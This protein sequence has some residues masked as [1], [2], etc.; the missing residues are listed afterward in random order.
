MRL[1][2]VAI[3]TAALMFFVKLGDVW[4]DVQSLMVSP[5]Y[6]QETKAKPEA[7][8]PNVTA[9]A[10][11]ASGEKGKGD[12]E[13]GGNKAGDANA[14]K[15]EAAEGGKTAEGAA[16]SA[17]DSAKDK[18]GG[19]DSKTT[20]APGLPDDPALFSQAEIE[21]LQKL[22]DRR[23]ELERWASD[24]RMRERL[25]KATELRLGKKVKELK[26]IQGTLKGLL[27]QYDKEQLAK[28][29]RL[30][31]IYETM[32]PKNAA[33]VFEKLEL[34]IL[35]DVIELMR[36]AKAAKIMGRMDVTIAKRITAELARRRKLD[37]TSTALISTPAPIPAPAAAPPAPAPTAPPAP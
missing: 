26:K 9:P 8:K 2:P 21:L 25:L 5:S 24:I 10:K 6:A 4:L 3:I 15:A 27:R 29:K 35:M 28:L 12:K 19:S 16:D 23:K 31:K 17:A 32:K 33:R 37:E 20:A 1:L 7:K 30:V 18:A 13:K 34:N 22:A 11:Q 14:A 36:E